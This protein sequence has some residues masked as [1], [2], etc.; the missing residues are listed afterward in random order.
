M[1]QKGRRSADDH[2]LMALACGATVE[3]A[4]RQ[5]G[6]SESTVYRRLAEHAFRQRLHQVRADMVERT[7]G[8]L[9]AAANE[10]VR[11]LVELLKRTL[12]EVR[13]RRRERGFCTVLAI[14][15]SGF[16]QK[17]LAGWPAWRGGVAEWFERQRRPGIGGRLALISTPPHLAE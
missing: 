6:V 13:P 7:A 2:L 3:V 17:R 5:A 8:T 11:A 4:A 16:A 14:M 9:T 12:P 15:P 10:A 1:A